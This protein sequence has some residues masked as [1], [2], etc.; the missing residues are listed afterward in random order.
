MCSV[1]QR[2]EPLALAGAAKAQM[3]EPGRY[4]A[5]PSWETFAFSMG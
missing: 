2:R 4:Y 3:I 1:S 5:L